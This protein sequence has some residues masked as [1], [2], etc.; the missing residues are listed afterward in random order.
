[1]S[2]KRWIAVVA[3]LAVAMTGCGS[4]KSNRSK[5]Y[6]PP[7]TTAARQAPSGNADQEDATAKSDARSFV[8]EVE[9]CFVDQQMY[10]AC[11][12][13]S[14]TKADIGSGPG[15][16]EVKAAGTADYTIVAHSKSG[17][18]F[19][20]EKKAGGTLTQTCDKPGQGGCRSDGS[21]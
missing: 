12:K 20:V 5:A 18:G 1:L 17:T 16:V 13:P 6:T 3:A 21:W 10:S 7:P 14:V 11:K 9:A 19:K 8:A 15:Q 2:T 4:S